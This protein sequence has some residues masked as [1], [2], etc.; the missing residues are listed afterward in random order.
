MKEE[1]EKRKAELE[2]LITQQK[3]AI[4]RSIG[5]LQYLE[6]GLGMVV[7]LLGPVEETPDVPTEPLTLDELGEVLGADSI[8]VV[9]GEVPSE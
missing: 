8:E 3:E 4:E 7:D 1:L 9:E 5:Q 2:V 6:G